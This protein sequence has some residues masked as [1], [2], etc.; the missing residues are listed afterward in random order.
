MKTK[1]FLV[2]LLGILATTGSDCINDGFLV[3]VNLDI[4]ACY[5]IKS[6]PN[7]SW[8]T[9]DPGPVIVRLSDQI[10]E[11]YLNKIKNAR[12]YDL[13][14]SVKGTFNGSVS[15][16]AYINNIP[17]LTFNGAWSDFATAQS[18]LGNSTHVTS[19]ANG[20]TELVRVLNL[21]KTNTAQTVSLSSNGSLADQLPVPE[22]LS[23]CLEILAQV[24]AEVQ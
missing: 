6:G 23:V 2:F 19:Q 3:A 21:F 16:T 14:V 13:K 5:A 20:I 7:P 18:L 9:S 4:P 15:G 24:D 1:V 10:D 22:G 17:L 12:F 11:S 8:T